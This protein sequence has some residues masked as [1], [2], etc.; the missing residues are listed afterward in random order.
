MILLAPCSAAFSAFQISSRSAYSFSSPGQ[1]LQQRRQPVLGGFV[2]LFLQ[3]FLFDLELN[4][5][6]L[7]PVQRLGL[8]V[9]LHAN[10][11]RRLIDQ[12]DRLVGQLAVGDVAVRQRGRGDDRRIGDLDAVMHLVALLE[13][14]Q[15][16]DRVFNAGLID[17]HLLE[18]PLERLVLLDVLAVL[19]ERRGADAM[20]LAARQRRLEHVAGIHRAF[21][22]PGA[23][24]G[25][26]LVDEQDDLAFLLRQIVEHRLEPLLEL[27]AELR[28][29]D[30]RAHVERQDALVLQALG[31]LAVDDA[32]REAF[33]DGGL[34]DT[35]LADQHRVVLG[36]PLQHL[37]R[38]ADLIV[39]ADD[40]IELAGARARGQVD[41]VFLERLALLFRTRIV[42]LFAAAHFLD[43]LL[44]RGARG[45]HLLERLAERTT[46]LD[47][48]QHEQLAGDE[49]IAALLRQLVG[50]VEQSAQIVR[51]LHV[52]AMALDLRQAVDDVGEQRAQPV[53]VDP[54]LDQQRPHAAALGVEHGQQQ[55]RRLDELVVAADRQR[56]GVGQRRLKSAGEFVLAHKL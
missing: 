54:R 29:R 55:V 3:R 4:N 47:R 19:I 13:A 16:R 40:R 39:A 10:A 32:L 1:R 31:H 42:D 11:R 17:Q 51:A 30:Q 52:A 21:G 56:L 25:V 18:A 48:R 9:D 27:A 22:A 14:A 53:D 35:R 24:H 2:L 20:Q 5:A 33:D 38:A 15:D 7:E 44:D 6:P 45:L 41:G 8:G 26:Q 28:A 23:H 12:I 37:D 34:A 46:I 36:A 49:L 43:R 50:D